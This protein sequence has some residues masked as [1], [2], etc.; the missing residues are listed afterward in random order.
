[1][2]NVWPLLLLLAPLAAHAEDLG[3]MWGTASEEEKYYKLVRVPIPEEVPLKAGC[4]D[5]LPDGRLAV[6]TRK[7]DVYFVEGAFAT[8]PAPKFQL[9][10]SGQDEI[11][12]ISHRDGDITITQFAEV[13]RLSDDDG[14]GRADRYRTLSNNWGYA[15][16]HEFAFGSKHD[17]EGNI[18]VALG[19]TGSYHSRQL[20][21][22]WCLKVTPDGETIP[23]A[24]A[25]GV[26]AASDPT[27]TA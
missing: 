24:A 23:S 2:R 6:G 18:W 5:V 21:R 3:A 16:G 25:C 11:F 7:G 27:P 22:G 20:F 12:G 9:F 14:D 10:A 4:F 13:T 19:L 26:P 8:P 17:R 1:M 15:E